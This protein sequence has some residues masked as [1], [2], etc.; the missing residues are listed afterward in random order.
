MTDDATPHL[1]QIVPPTLPPLLIRGP[2]PQDVTDGL[3]AL[4]TACR[5]WK[6]TESAPF[7]SPT[8]WASESSICD[9]LIGIANPAEDALVSGVMGG[10]V[11]TLLMFGVYALVRDLYR[12]LRF[13][14]VRKMSERE[15]LAAQ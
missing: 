12:G 10:V 5:N 11:L 9:Q 15:H 8:A 14:I 1:D 6:P 13:F 2:A 4:T 3:N 7:K